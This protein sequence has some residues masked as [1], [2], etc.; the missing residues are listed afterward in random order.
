L[1]FFTKILFWY[2]MGIMEK[3]HCKLY[4]KHKACGHMSAGFTLIS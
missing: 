3:T 2:P 4:E 1:G